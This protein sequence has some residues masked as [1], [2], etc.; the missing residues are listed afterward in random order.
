LFLKY[1]DYTNRMEIIMQM[2]YWGFSR[3]V[4]NICQLSLIYIGKGF[5]P[6]Q[7]LT[8]EKVAKNLYCQYLVD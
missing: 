8:L 3:G 1:I 7:I 5:N 4:E 2:L 6:V